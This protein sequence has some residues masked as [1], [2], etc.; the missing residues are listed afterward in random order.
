MRR[1]M[2]L[3][4]CVLMA[5]VMMPPVATAGPRNFPRALF[6][7]L[8]NPIGTVLQS[9]HARHHRVGH[10]RA[11]A[12]SRS[13]PAAAAAATAAA[14]IATAGTK[15]ASVAAPETATSQAPLNAVQTPVP[16]PAAA[17]ETPGAEEPAAETAQK[18][19]EPAGG[20]NQSQPQRAEA[21]EPRL[22]LV[23]P[24]VWPTA[25]EDVVGYLLWPQQYGQRLLSHGIG[26]V[27][28][29]AFSPPSALMETARA[30]LP[31]GHG[32]A[33][34]QTPG[35]AGQ[36][37]TTGTGGNANAGSKAGLCASTASSD[38][39]AAAIEKSITLTD[40]QRDAL[41]NLQAAQHAAI[42]SIRSTCHDNVNA[43]PVERLRAMQNTLWA[44]HDAVLQ[45]RAPLA[46]FYNSLTA[47]Q[48][49]QFAAPR[50]R[51]AGADQ[52]E[53][54]KLCGTP[55]PNALPRQEIEQSLQPN[56]AQRASLDALQKKASEMGQFLM[57]SCMRPV[58]AT[59]G[60]RLDAATDRL[61]AMAF[62]V[63]NV[64]IAVDDFYGRLS[65]GQ[66][67]KLVAMR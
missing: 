56:K 50:S 15:A 60:G 17:A 1:G 47:E 41:N 45:L 33:Q 59:P 57:A 64:A 3:V 39:P 22:G 34:T 35:K 61:T 30:A 52:G 9:R 7:F 16:V 27:L 67:A 51:Q 19:P 38:W 53:L 10:R 13:A 20:N 23:G 14:G 18:S 54:A 21:P 46:D 58:A 40:A 63:S 37:E 36:P 55:A 6:G 26:D 62:A 11:I 2:I 12:R 65:D 8:T 29:T 49:Q 5:A 42:L 31:Q 66:K 44:V 4:T 32:Q 48:K 28:R 24:L 25:Y 43:S